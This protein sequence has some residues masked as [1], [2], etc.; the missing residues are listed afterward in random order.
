MK[1]MVK[2]FQRSV[3]LEEKKDWPGVIHHAQTWTQAQP[4]DNQAWFYLGVAYGQSRQITKE[5][6]AYSRAG[7]L[8]LNYTRHCSTLGRF[9]G[10]NNSTELIKPETM[11]YAA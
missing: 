2:W 9:L 7:F 11:P 6:E 10:K 3:E 5:I 4:K 1:T 8:T